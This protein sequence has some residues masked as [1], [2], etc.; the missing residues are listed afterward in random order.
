MYKGNFSTFQVSF[1]PH[2]KVTF[3][4][5]RDTGPS[6]VLLSWGSLET[7]DPSYNQCFPL[8]FSIFVCNVSY[9]KVCLMHCRNNMLYKKHWKT[10]CDST[11]LE[12]FFCHRFWSHLRKDVLQDEDLVRR[13]N[14]TAVFILTWW[15]SSSSWLCERIILQMFKCHHLFQNHLLMW[16][17]CSPQ[18]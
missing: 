11:S 1:L 16:G 9:S 7:G 10:Y 2:F 13:R 18:K 15:P 14:L 12:D 3:T 17:Y 5:K 6:E 8:E 4:L